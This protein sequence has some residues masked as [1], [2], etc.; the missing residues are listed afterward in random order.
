MRIFVLA[1][2]IMAVYAQELLVTQ[3]YTDYLKKHVDWEVVDYEENIFRGWTIDEAK[4]LLNDVDLEQD[5]YYDDSYEIDDNAPSSIDWSGANC[6]HGARNQGSCSS[7]WALAM[8]ELLGI[9]CCLQ[10]TDHGFL[11]PQELVSCNTKNNKG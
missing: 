11:S 10:G 9:R 5:D 8:V 6:D 4:T 7:Q 3:E 2:A 1:L